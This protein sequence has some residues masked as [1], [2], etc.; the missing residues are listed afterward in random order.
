MRMDD[1][2]TTAEPVSPTADVGPETKSATET[3]GGISKVV[4]FIYAV[5]AAIAIAAI[6]LYFSGKL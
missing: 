6:L 1:V 4:L 3:I 2:R 5:V